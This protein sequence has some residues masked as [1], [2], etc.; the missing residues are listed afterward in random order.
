VVPYFPL[1]TPQVRGDLGCDSITGTGV[2]VV[3]I[4]SEGDRVICAML[5]RPGA[6]TFQLAAFRSASTESL[7]CLPLPRVVSCRL[8]RVACLPQI[9][10][11]ISPEE[12]RPFPV[13]ALSSR[14]APGNLQTSPIKLLPVL[15][16]MSILARKL[17]RDCLILQILAQM[18]P[19]LNGGLHF[20][21]DN[22][23]RVWFR[24]GLIG[25]GWFFLAAE[26]RLAASLPI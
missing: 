19:K 12:P 20:G 22:V 26:P 5:S 17:Q 14:D 11:E 13:P 3:K 10:S 2:G 9:A 7:L 16:L 8:R 18:F 24:F 4:R 21:R 23:Y 15:T 25:R 1:T 6:Q